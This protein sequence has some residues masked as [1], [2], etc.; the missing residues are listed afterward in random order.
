MGKSNGYRDGRLDQALQD[1]ALLYF[2]SFQ[3]E[4]ER[5]YSFSQGIFS[6][7]CEIFGFSPL[8]RKVPVTA[9][10]ARLHHTK[11]MTESLVRLE[12]TCANAIAY[13]FHAT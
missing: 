9:L 5:F 10:Q 4:R 7:A 12:E 3:N 2:V 6:N 11:A 8:V 1:D 13:F